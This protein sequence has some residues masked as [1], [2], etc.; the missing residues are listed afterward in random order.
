MTLMKHFDADAVNI[1]VP[2]MCCDICAATCDCE[3]VNCSSYAK[4]PAQD[5]Q[6][7]NEG[8]HQEINVSA[9]NK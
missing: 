3:Q 2:H 8:T 4:Y 6:N 7:M 9:E 1:E 5:I